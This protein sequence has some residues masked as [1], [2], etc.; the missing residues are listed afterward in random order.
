M[1]PMPN[2]TTTA[3]ITG[4]ATNAGTTTVRDMNADTIMEKASTAATRR[5]TKAAAVIT[6]TE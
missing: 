1:I 6:K 5:L 4:K 2:A 3:I